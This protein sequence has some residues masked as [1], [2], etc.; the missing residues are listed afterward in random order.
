MG[1]RDPATRLEVWL[2]QTHQDVMK[3]LPIYFDRIDAFS[4]PLYGFDTSKLKT[5]REASHDVEGPILDFLRRQEKAGGPPT[6]VCLVLDAVATNNL[7]VERGFQLERERNADDEDDS[8]ATDH[9]AWQKEFPAIYVRSTLHLA[10]ATA[11]V[12][13]SSTNSSSSGLLRITTETRASWTSVDSPKTGNSK[14]RGAP[15][16]TI[17]EY[18]P[19][20]GTATSFPHSEWEVLVSHIR[21]D[22]Q[23]PSL[24]FDS[25]S[26]LQYPSLMMHQS[27]AISFACEQDSNRERESVSPATESPGF[28]ARSVSQSNSVDLALFPEGPPQ[29]SFHVI[30]LS[31]YISMAV[32]VMAEEESR[33]H[34]RRGRLSDDQIRLFLNSMA[35]TLRLTNLFMPERL[36]A[37][38]RKIAKAL[39]VAN[40]RAQIWNESAIQDFLRRLKESFDLQPIPTHD[41]LL[42]SLARHSP[43]LSDGRLAVLSRRLKLQQQLASVSPAKSA[44]EWFLGPELAQILDP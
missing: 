19:D 38:P 8:L 3:L 17:L 7:N 27:T 33:W 36:P 5:N 16:W 22:Q 34:R 41:T 40:D 13:A 18:G 35:T 25:L 1:S 31:K 11:A 24:S 4:S 43:N 23:V 14:K 21:R 20:T 6:A 37:P 29:S 26:S 28:F 30:S 44:A 15:T 10:A 42:S 12:S 39:S 9:E 32:I 2:N